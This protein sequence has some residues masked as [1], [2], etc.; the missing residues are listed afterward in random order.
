MKVGIAM[1]ADKSCSVAQFP[2]SSNGH[3]FMS[4]MSDMR[5]AVV[6]VICGMRSVLTKT[7]NWD[8]MAGELS[9]R[10]CGM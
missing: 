4:S 1:P 2:A 8:G 7:T 5:N 9:F 10:F 3:Q 6:Q